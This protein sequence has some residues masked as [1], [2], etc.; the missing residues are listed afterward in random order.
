MNFNSS[1]FYPSVSPNSNPE[2]FTSYAQCPTRY[3]PQRPPSSS[4]PQ[5]GLL[6]QSA[7]FGY[8]PYSN[9][10]NP[11]YERPMPEPEEMI[12]TPNAGMPENYRQ[13]TVDTIGQNTKNR[14]Y[15]EDFAKRKAICVEILPSSRLSTIKWS[16][17]N[18]YGEDDEDTCVL[19]KQIA[20]SNS[21]KFRAQLG[22]E[23][24]CC[25]ELIQI[26]DNQVIASDRKKFKAI[27]S[28]SEYNELFDLSVAI[29][30]PKPQQEFKVMYRAKP[31]IYWDDLI[32]RTGSIMEVYIKDNNGH[33][34]ASPFGDVRFVVPADRLLSPHYVNIYF[35]D[36]YCN[37]VPHY[38]TIV[39][40]EKN[41]NA[42]RFCRR[43]V[44]QLNFYDN[45]FLTVKACGHQNGKGFYRYYVNGNA[46]VEILYTKGYKN[47]WRCEK[48]NI[49]KE[50]ST[51]FGNS[52]DSVPSTIDNREEIDP[53]RTPSPELPS[54]DET[55][56]PSM[57]QRKRPASTDLDVEILEK[58][59]KEEAV[60]AGISDENSTLE[61]KKTPL[62]IAIEEDRANRR[63]VDVLPDGEIANLVAE[64][65]EEI[66]T[67]EDI[68]LFCS[69]VSVATPDEIDGIKKLYEDTF[70]SRYDKCR[71]LLHGLQDRV[72]AK[73]TSERSDDLHLLASSYVEHRLTINEISE[74]YFDAYIDV[75]DP[76]QSDGLSVTEAKRRLQDGGANVIKP[77]KE[78]SNLKLFAKQF[79]YKFWIL[80]LGAAILSITIYFIHI[81]HGNTET[82]NLYCAF[83][84]IG[85]V[86]FMSVLSFIQE[87]LAMKVCSHFKFP[88]SAFVIRD[89]T[90]QKVN[91][92]DLVVGHPHP[93]T[94]TH[95]ASARHTSVFDAKNVVFKGS[96]CVE[97]NAIGVLLGNVADLQST[98]I[99]TESLLQAEISKFVQFVSIIAL[100][101]A[102]FFFIVGVL[103]ARFENVLY[104]FVTG[105]LIIIVANV[106]Q[107]LPATVMSQLSIIARRMA[108]KN[109][110]IKKLDVIDEL[111]ACSVILVDKT[112]VLTQNCLIL[113]D[114]WYNLKHYSVHIHSKHHMRHF[115]N[116]T[117][118]QEPL[119]DILSVMSVCNSASMADRRPFHRTITTVDAVR[120]RFQIL[121]E[122]PF[123]SRR[124]WQLVI[125]RCLARPTGFNA[126]KFADLSS[127]RWLCIV[128]MKGAPDVVLERCSHTLINGQ[129]VEIDDE[130][131]QTCQT[132]WQSRS[133]MGERVIAFAE[134][135]FDVPANQKFT[136][137]S[138][139]P[140][141]ELVFLGIASLVD[142]PRIESSEAI[143]QAKEA[144]L[145]IFMMRNSNTGK[146]Q[147]EW[148][149]VLGESLT[150]MTTNE[151][152]TL[153]NYRYIVFARTNAEQKLRI[154]K[155]CQRRG[156]RVAVTGSGVNDSP[157]LATANVGIA[158]GINGSDIAQKAADIIL[159]ND[160]FSSIVK[161]IEEG[162]LLFD[163][164]RLS[165]AY[166][167]AHL[168]P[169]IFPI[170]INTTLGMPLGLEPLQI[171]SID[172]ASELPPAVSL[173]YESPERD[174]MKI[175]PRGRDTELMS[176]QLLLYSYGFTGTIITAGCF[177][178]YLSV[179]WHYNIR[180]SDLLY[181]AEHHWK[182]DAMNFTTSD[183]RVFDSEAQMFIR[184]A[185]QVTLVI[186]QVFH[187]FM[188]T[189]RRVSFFRHGITN[190]VTVFA[191]IIEILLLNLFVYTP[192][193]RYFMD[194]QIPPINVWF[195]AP[196]VGL[197][198]VVFNET[199]KFLIRNYPTSRIS[200]FFE[201]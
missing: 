40:C 119:S 155:E 137:N 59:A 68:E 174:I 6:P 63:S 15:F 49:K 76:A 70:L 62:Q 87:R 117:E 66:A 90:E 131:R 72:Y 83:I 26:A 65:V 144:G 154:V 31:K 168:W 194:I 106:P 161:G 89:G 149:I 166:T 98:I 177:M 130:F 64:I 60:D 109:V 2:I 185:W 30:G 102:T 80:L 169:E 123:N 152:D 105:F 55:P 167:L 162:R 94:Y 32:T 81:A 91:A 79:L 9:P 200:H 52:G 156:E 191:V 142:P 100:V 140:S 196:V 172:L 99:V 153:L 135:H 47:N 139:Y 8:H 35:A 92:S 61:A 33:A 116:R 45:P 173:A 179:Y 170:V 178:A 163:N 20:R 77:P 71:R 128:M 121:L 86:I 147:K 133:A 42:D 75:E 57:G 22:V 145:K 148:T 197:Y 138:D 1:G 19:L 120:Q 44:K 198:L 58:K 201:W 113:T 126:T 51:L 134:Y 88:Q 101:M 199:R 187:L 13:C 36:F 73:E 175:P 141:N 122:I 39:V 4:M 129:M 157:T 7:R 24:E 124:R 186:S 37:R 96:Y 111:G 136:A 27:F 143:R 43:H 67:H 107:G 11:H 3:G 118:L 182:E 188:V 34:T 12:V 114:L 127:D 38:V 41:S 93:I 53:E 16:L 56:A 5:R 176:Y 192:T 29:T 69:D 150:N 125:S 146:T 21:Y 48:C 115:I 171:L 50:A 97:G 181:T 195:Y 180:I 28:L 95:E 46:H 103:V 160:D 151:W 183:G 14:T 82:L 17:L 104:H 164:L 23:Y 25:V 78:I 74:I 193:L 189:T 54:V 108:K 132:E 159:T 85:I 190:L 84:L 165:I 158:M 110:Y 18:N 10:M 112:G 184:A